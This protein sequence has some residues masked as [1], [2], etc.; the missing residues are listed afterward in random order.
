MWL[1][2]VLLTLP[3]AV[4]AARRSPAAAAPG[5]VSFVAPS[6]MLRGKTTAV[7]EGKQL[8]RGQAP[9][10]IGVR[11]GQPTVLHFSGWGEPTAVTSLMR[12]TLELL[13][14]VIAGGAILG[15]IL[16]FLVVLVWVA[17]EISKA[18]EKH[19]ENAEKARQRR[20]EERAKEQE[21]MRRE[22][23]SDPKMEWDDRLSERQPRM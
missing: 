8:Q 10:G 19:R 18:M 14:T 22:A 1:P 13:V 6:L 23:A 7:A 20:E 17:V 9:L 2:A 21:R 3:H 15:I 12:F 11:R 5:S 4:G 16:M